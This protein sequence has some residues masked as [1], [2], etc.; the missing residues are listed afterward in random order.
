M[1][2]VVRP[3]NTTTEMAAELL[4]TFADM[5]AGMRRSDAV[6]IAAGNVTWAQHQILQVVISN[7]RPM[8]VSDLAAQICLSVAS[9][10]VATMRL[11]QQ[12]LIRRVSDPADHRSVL[13]AVT[14]KGAAA[15]GTSV[16]TAQ[17]LLASKLS[18]L[19]ESQLRA[20]RDSLPA[21]TRLI[22]LAAVEPLYGV[23]SA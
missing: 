9:T 21:L 1:T 14:T 19:D 17:A 4:A 16:T 13:I 22:Q 11:Q 20:L 3:E 8:R 10:T 23:P 6:R 5:F 7:G 2:Q 15:H 12:R 18:T